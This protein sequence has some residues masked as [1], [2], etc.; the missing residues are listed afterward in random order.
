MIWV[1]TA[2]FIFSTIA[3][4]YS[5]K[6]Y[7]NADFNK[8]DSL[9]FGVA[10]A[11]NSI[12]I[13]T[14]MIFLYIEPYYSMIVVI[15]YIDTLVF[16]TF[17]SVSIRL[18]QAN[19]ESSN[20]SVR[21]TRSLYLIFKFLI[22]SSFIA[23]IIS[24]KCV[25]PERV[26]MMLL[27]RPYMDIILET[28]HAGIAFI[29]FLFVPSISYYIFLKIGSLLFSISEILQVYNVWKFDYN[30]TLIENYEHIIAILGF[31]SLSIGVILLQKFVEMHD[32]R[33]SKRRN[34]V[35]LPFV[36]KVI[37]EQKNE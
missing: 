24:S 1:L 5:I 37:K 16:L 4:Y 14:Q 31:M 20:F 12:S 3:A 10:F 26:N 28:F 36:K 33:K 15:H 21:I 34:T 25:E 19:I 13:I 11:I 32:K 17:L 29:I 23:F 9:Y 2:I 22:L 8:I 18:F 27:A 30:N 6:S 7:V 35:S